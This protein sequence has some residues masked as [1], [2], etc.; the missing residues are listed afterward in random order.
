MSA[1]AP[2]ARPVVGRERE[3]GLLA[4]AWQRCATDGPQ[5]AL[6]SGE[7]G[8]GK[9]TLLREFASRLGEAGR[10]LLGQ[11]VGGFGD[12]L[13]YA[14]ISQA[15][16]ELVA[17]CGAEQVA[18]WAGAGHEALGVVLPALRAG[19]SGA[20]RM[21]VFEAVA[22]V[23]EGAARQRP[24]V[25]VIED[26]H[27]AD[28]STAALLRFLEAGL[29][30]EPL[31]IV[32]TYRSDELTGRHPLRP[33]VA[34]LQRRPGA[35]RVPLDALD[36]G[37]VAQLV[38]PILGER[39][40]A[41]NIARIVERSEGV[42][43]FAEELASSELRGPLPT[44]LS[45]ALLTRVQGLSDAARRLVRLVAPG[46]DAASHELLAA[47]T[48]LDAET[49]EQA[50][51]EAIEAG[52]LVA[53]DDG[54][55]FRHALLRDAVHDD[56]LPGE[57]ARLHGRLA[58]LLLAH[59]ELSTG[60][61]RLARHLLEANR[62]NEAF[63]ACFTAAEEL[64]AAGLDR[65]EQYEAALRIWDQVDDPEAVI[66]G[67]RDRLLELAARAAYWE[68]WDPHALAL[69][70]QS[71]AETPPDTDPLVRSRRL[72]LKARAEPDKGESGRI[73][74]QAFDLTPADEPTIGRA[75]VLEHLAAV[76]MIQG[77]PEQGI[78]LA[79]EG[80]E[81]ARVFQRVG[82]ISNLM[83]TKGCCQCALGLEDAG[84]ALIEEAGQLLAPRRR[85]R[86]H[87]NFGHHL[88]YYGDY[89]RA[90]DVALAGVEVARSFGV[91]RHI[92]AMLAG[93][94][95]E[96]LLALGEWDEAERTAA[97][98]LALNPGE[99]YYLQLRLLAMMLAWCRGDHAAI[100]EINDEL[101]PILG[102]GGGQPQLQTSYLVPVAELAL[103]QGEPER[104]WQLVAA[105]LRRGMRQSPYP[106]WQLVCLARK[107]LARLDRDIAADL[108]WLHDWA[109]SIP[110]ARVTPLFEA[111]FAAEG[112]DSLAGWRAVLDALPTALPVWLELEAHARAAEA[113]LRAGELDAAAQDAQSGAEVAER[114]GDRHWRER[115]AALASAAGVSARPQRRDAGPGVLTPREVEV[116]RL[117]A[118][119]RSNGEIGKTLFVSAKTVSV[120]VSNILAKL[121]VSGRGE[122]AAWAHRNG[123]AELPGDPPP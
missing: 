51:R 87:T 27:W 39:A 8:L 82:L 67:G 6:V 66:G 104:A 57:L 74:Q 12:A 91:E 46:R 114:V 75:D 71:L 123:L 59:P 113:A 78:R 26:L 9:T 96:V 48:E 122:A 85:L 54:Y 111:W 10:V 88:N 32:V 42:P 47:A 102:G 63:A 80:L 58:D 72:L 22:S 117:V 38:R 36:A 11:C 81:I 84:L 37:E 33:L 3:L 31:L 77:E 45:E 73:A 28:P 43:F 29:A 14:P 115:F 40:T 108:E 56:M 50:L 19:A 79:D 30:R 103:A 90:A 100:A 25:L 16:K 94:L 99:R 65:L 49:L 21:Q 109:A 95:A 64:R 68:D 15:L 101:E 93:N 76:A 60:S 53:T 121:G 24:V 97:R 118:E 7:A 2:P 70:D 18:Q 89:Q 20:E 41:A 13:P 119:G 4:A 116:L 105:E 23:L 55:G 107:T 5:L 1:A 17:E 69:I 98:A 112:D 61:T 120:H 86:Y 44:T 106:S 92:G 34:E 110:K 35:V 62:P 83:I 52:V